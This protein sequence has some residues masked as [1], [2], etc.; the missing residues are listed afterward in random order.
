MIPIAI[1]IKGTKNRKPVPIIPN[2]I[3]GVFNCASTM[4]FDGIKIKSSSLFSQL[5]NRDPSSPFQLFAK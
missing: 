2:I 4:V 5:I 1:K 3:K